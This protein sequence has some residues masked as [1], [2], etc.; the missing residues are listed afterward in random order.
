MRFPSICVASLACVLLPALGHA[1]DEARPDETTRW[2]PAIGAWSS[3]LIQHADAST[4]SSDVSFDSTVRTRVFQ[5]TPFPGA[6]VEQITIENVTNPL[7]PPA[8][9]DDRLVTAAIS[10]TL[11]LMTPGIQRI[12]GRPRFFAHGDLGAAFGQVRHV[13]RERAPGNLEGTIETPDGPLLEEI[14]FF[15]E[16]ALQDI[17][18]E[19]TAEVQPFLISAGVGVAFSFDLFGRRLRIKPSVEYLRE[20]IDLTGSVVRGARIDTGI[21]QFPP[22][23]PQR[24][25]LFIPIELNGNTTEEFHGIGPGL[26]IEMDTRRAGPFM[27]S[28]FVSGQAYKILGDTEVKFSEEQTL[29]YPQLTPTPQTVSA[30]WSFE[31]DPWGY[32]AGVGLRFRWQPE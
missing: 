5:P 23:I 19:T 26:E 1:E 15:P 3:V 30:D 22:F 29:T 7:Q 32:R 9:G 28:L 24:P 21:Q 17:G 31:K 20:E 13:A 4:S 16:E 11:E 6:F 10:G 12:P 14:A 8:S 18:S 2:T 25:S 27:L